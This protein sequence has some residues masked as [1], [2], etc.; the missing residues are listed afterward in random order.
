MTLEA[1]LDEC[2]AR[3]I[4]LSAAGDRLKVDAPVGAVTSELR[5]SLADHKAELLAYLAGPTEQTT[6]EP[7]VFTIPLEGMSEW[8]AAHRLRIVGGDSQRGMVY[9]AD[10]A[11]QGESA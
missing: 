1:L 7:E 9:L 11:D 10:I 5:Q 6:S 8:L 3:G 4:T 2:A